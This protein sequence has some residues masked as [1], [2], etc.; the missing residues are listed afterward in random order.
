MN[1]LYAKEL[2]QKY[3]VFGHFYDLT[4]CDTTLNC[5]NTLEIRRNKTLEEIP[6]II[7]IMMNP[8][9]SKPLDEKH[10]VK[11]YRF[12]GYLKEKNF[13]LIPTKPD[14]AQYQIMR[15][16]ELNNWNFVRILNLSDLRNGNSSNF[17]KEFKKALD[18]DTSSP[19][20]ITHPKRKQELKNALISKTNKIIAAWGEIK[21]LENSAKEILSL[22][23]EIIGVPRENPIFFQ[24]ASP[25][26]K[27]PKIK[28]LVEIQKLLSDF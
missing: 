24:Y 4:I 11:N 8:G 7:V 12:E 21:E 14:S 15:L 28:W 16:M 9:S 20:C 1:F 23:F 3:Q 26:Y 25:Y 2:K 6:D 18:V 19:H 27:E 22:D 10:V 17:K 13:T 5:R